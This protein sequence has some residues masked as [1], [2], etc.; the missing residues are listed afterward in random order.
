MSFVRVENAGMFYWS[1]IAVQ[2][3][4]TGFAA[5]L[6]GVCLLVWMPRWRHRVDTNWFLKAA[7][8]SQSWHRWKT[9]I[10]PSLLKENWFAVESVMDLAH[11]RAHDHAGIEL[12]LH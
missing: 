12:Y 3:L 5:V 4:R 11:S 2:L 6:A 9:L 10:Y 7:L 8:I 1:P